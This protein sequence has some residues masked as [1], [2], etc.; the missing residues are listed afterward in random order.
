ML[1]LRHDS[2]PPCDYHGASLFPKDTVASRESWW[3]CNCAVV[4]SE[5]IVQRWWYYDGQGRQNQRGA[6]LQRHGVQCPSQAEGGEGW[7]TGLSLVFRSKPPAP[8]IS[9]KGPTLV[10]RSGNLIVRKGFELSFLWWQKP[11]PLY[12]S[13]HTVVN[14]FSSLSSFLTFSPKWFTSF[15]SPF[16]MLTTT[17]FLCSQQPHWVV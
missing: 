16:F 2:W 7:A 14:V 10:S 1:C 3:V 13:R 6:M 8:H 12:W 11:P 5:G 9:L 4:V 17:P 15:P